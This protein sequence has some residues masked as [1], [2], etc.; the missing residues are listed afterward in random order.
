M[1]VRGL[2]RP[3]AVGAAR[4]FEFVDESVHLLVGFRLPNRRLDTSKPLTR[5]DQ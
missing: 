3:V 2:H 1:T 5:A 4:A